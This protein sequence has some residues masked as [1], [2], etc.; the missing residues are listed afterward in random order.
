MTLK[1]NVYVHS[2]QIKNGRDTR[3]L[4][5]LVSKHHAQK[6]YTLKYLPNV[7]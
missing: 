7:V 4:F 1:Y 3:K 5:V 2:V 6:L